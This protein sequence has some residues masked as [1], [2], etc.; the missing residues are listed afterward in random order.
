MEINTYPDLVRVGT[1]TFAPCKRVS[2]GFEFVPLN[3]PNISTL[4]FRAVRYYFPPLIHELKRPPS[5]VSDTS[6]LWFATLVGH[7]LLP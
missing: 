6:V 7:D 4:G 2:R 3:V 5:C 1:S